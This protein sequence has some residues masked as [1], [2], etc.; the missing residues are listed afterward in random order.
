MIESKRFGDRAVDVVVTIGLIMLSA[1]F[2]YPLLHV[3]MASFSDPAKLMSHQG[4]LL[5]P[6]GFSLEGY[7][8][9]L[10]NP[11]ILMGYKNTLIYVVCGTALNILLTSMGAYVLSRR[12]LI[13][14]K[15]LTILIV[16]TMYF[17]GG[18]IPN[19]LLVKSLGL[20]NSRLALI[21]PGAIATWNLIVMKTS[22]QQIPAGLEESA[23]ID[24]ANDFVILFRI[25]MPVAR[26]TVAVMVLFY[27]VGHWNSW[28]NAMVYL[29]D[30]V[31]FPLQL[32][33]REILIANSTGGNV[34][35]SAGEEGVFLL[36]E[37]IKYCTIVISTLPILCIYPMIQKY[38]V[39]GV[40]MGSLKE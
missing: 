19:F 28:F 40:M 6:D 7:K 25:I 34:F 26:A 16:F 15:P 30:R 23:K 36:D 32:L 18:L 4:L 37:L 27:A 31:K 13:F 17:S 20:Y 38:F 11:N 1:I 14:K 35:E 2:F 10:N 22:F 8:V 9:V 12:K 24:G 3:L 39:T 29:R 5:W 21:I 33:L